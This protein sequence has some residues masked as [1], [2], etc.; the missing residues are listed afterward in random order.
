MDASARA[1]GVVE[2]ASNQ[3]PTDRASGDRARS[4]VPGDGRPRF[5]GHAQISTGKPLRVTRPGLRVS[6]IQVPG[7]EQAPPH[8]RPASV[9][10][11]PV[12][13]DPPFEH[14]L[15]IAA[16]PSV[17]AA[18]SSRD[19]ARV[20][21]LV[22]LREPQEKVDV[23]EQQ[24]RIRASDGLDRASPDDHAVCLDRVGDEQP[25]GIDRSAWRVQ[26][27]GPGSRERP[28]ALVDVLVI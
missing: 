23:G 26:V 20:H 17:M 18:I 13:R 1:R 27:G 11:A 9:K 22:A 5:D 12:E 4:P 25:E 14:Q 8:R 6:R 3:E 28:Q 24:R 21:D 15:W 16:H 2:V 7:C 19:L 10:M